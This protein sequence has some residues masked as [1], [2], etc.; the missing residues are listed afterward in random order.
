MSQE[1]LVE[2]GEA[3]QTLLDTSVFNQTINQL[4]ES[5]YTTFI[6]T[7][8]SEFEAR[9]TAYQHYQA[10]VDIVST[11]RQK[12]QIKDEILATANQLEDGEDHV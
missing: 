5:T 8:P 3:A 10:I 11:L 7:K 4:V 2:Q 9:E 1:E 6:N 12:V